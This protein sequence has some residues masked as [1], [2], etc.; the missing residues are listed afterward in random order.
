MTKDKRKHSKIGNLDKII[1]EN[2]RSLRQAEKLSQRHLA[3]I[4][5]VTFQQVQKYESGLNRLPMEALYILHKHFG[6]PYDYFFG[7]PHMA[8]FY[9]DAAAFT[10]C[11]QIAGVTDPALK[12]KITAI[13]KIL[14]D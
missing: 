12:N 3:D 9:G 11:K 6:L 8:P 2:I 5:G 13:V 10:L 1:G 14:I 7:E 4:I